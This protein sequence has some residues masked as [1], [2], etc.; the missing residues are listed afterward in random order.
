ML[1]PEKAEC[2]LCLSGTGWLVECVLLACFAFVFQLKEVI[3]TICLALHRIA[4]PCVT[5]KKKTFITEK[6]IPS[7]RRRQ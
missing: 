6:Y 2:A 4:E 7:A 3:D 5:V 1:V